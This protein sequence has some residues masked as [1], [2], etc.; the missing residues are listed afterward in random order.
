MKSFCL[1]DSFY[2]GN[3]SSVV[4]INAADLKLFVFKIP[5]G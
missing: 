1:S 3:V 5:S 2:Y 4:V